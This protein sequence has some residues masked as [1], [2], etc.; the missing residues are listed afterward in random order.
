MKFTSK[1]DQ[2]ISK[3][4]NKLSLQYRFKKADGS[5]CVVLDRSF[6][7]FDEA[8]KPFRMIGSMQD[9]T[10]R[11]NYMQAIEIQNQKLKEIAWIQ[12]HM[13]RAPLTN[14]MGLVELIDGSPMSTIEMEEIFD[15][16]KLA[17]R[18][19]DLALVEIIKK[20]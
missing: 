1:F 8:G 3:R 12:A 9:I 14:I 15:R 2:M 11:V 10:D 20:G 6:L 7:L 4:Q 17:A 18:S 16:L 5:F 19:L 13:V